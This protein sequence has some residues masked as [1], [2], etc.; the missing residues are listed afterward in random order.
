MGKYLSTEELIGERFKSVIIRDS[1]RNVEGKGRFFVC[2]CDCGQEL[3]LTLSALKRNVSLCDCQKSLIHQDN[4]GKKYHMLTIKSPDPDNIKNVIVS[5]DCGNEKSVISSYLLLGKTKSCGCLSKSKDVV[6]EIHNRFTII[7]NLPS[8]KYGNSR[9]K[10]VKAQ[11]QCGKIK[12][13][14]Y[15][16]LKN[17]RIK[18]CGC[19]I[20]E[21]KIKVNPG[22]IYNNWTIIAEGI[23]AEGKTKKSRTVD[24][25]CVCGKI[26]KNR[27]FSSIYT[28]KSKSCGC[29]GKPKKEVIIKDITPT[30][31][32]T[33]FKQWRNAFGFEGY[34]ISTEGEVFNTKTKNYIKT[35]NKTT[36][37]IATQDKSLSFNIAKV[38]YK[39]FI[40][41]YDDKNNIILFLDD[42]PKNIKLNNLFLAVK[43]KYG[44][45]W[46]AGLVSSVNKQRII[47]GEVVIL[48]KTIDKGDVIERYLIQN[49]LSTFLKI[50]MDLTGYDKMKSVSLDRIDNNKGYVKGNITLVTRFENMGRGNMEFEPFMEF[51]ESLRCNT[52]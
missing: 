25:K 15:K 40:G 49:G 16:D 3:I 21:L 17:E 38:M 8:I 52:N 46:V 4:I 42:N 1:I 29:K 7:E 13:Y 18:S 30:P 22:D 20:E 24:V 37:N 45:S 9:H 50:L 41:D 51:C 31:I 43:D 34:L 11:C 5:C 35:L 10:R 48:E 33:D 26:V 14:S 27:N 36:V 39:T 28:G 12:E 6:G 47:N 2:D 44:N 23:L 32:S 19:Y